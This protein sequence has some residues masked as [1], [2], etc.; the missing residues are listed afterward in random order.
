MSTSIPRTNWHG[1]PS[2]GSFRWGSENP[3]PA[4][5]GGPDAMSDPSIAYAS[6]ASGWR[7]E[8][9]SL[10][11]RAGQTACLTPKPRGRT[12]G[13][14]AAAH[15]SARTSIARATWWAVAA[16][17]KLTPVVMMSVFA[18]YGMARAAMQRY[19][20]EKCERALSGENISEVLRPFTAQLLTF[21]EP[22]N[23][24][25]HCGKHASYWE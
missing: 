22:N 25:L 1:M 5:C 13:S 18:A 9:V 21:G 12:S 3:R 17:G 14:N 6:M 20:D 10:T 2:G 4:M 24:C 7:F 23:S 19:A 15:S 8:A 16:T 11:I